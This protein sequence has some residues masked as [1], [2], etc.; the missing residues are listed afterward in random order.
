MEKNDVKGHL[1]V[2]CFFA[3][4]WEKFAG[5][6]RFRRSTPVMLCYLMLCYEC[7]YAGMYGGKKVK[8]KLRLITD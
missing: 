8:D 4:S 3:R 6:C 1:C 2:F 5:I 7:T